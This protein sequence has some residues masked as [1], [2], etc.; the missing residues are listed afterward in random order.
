MLSLHAA[1]PTFD[2][3]PALARPQVASNS[4]QPTPS[5]PVPARRRLALPA[6]PLELALPAEPGQHCLQGHWL[7]A[8]EGEEGLQVG[9]AE[10][11]LA[12]KPDRLVEH[13]LPP[14]EQSALLLGELQTHVVFQY[15]LLLAQLRVQGDQL[16][17]NFG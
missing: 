7:E 9:G 16:A 14:G 2:L 10:V 17:L 3:L 5:L 8:L 1:V 6:L 11:Q 15:G 4:P 12:G 13:G